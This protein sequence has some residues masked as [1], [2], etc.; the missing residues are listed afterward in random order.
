MPSAQTPHFE[1]P[2]YEG[3]EI[4]RLGL[5]L[6]VL[7]HLT[8]GPVWHVDRNAIDTYL[9]RSLENDC[10]FPHRAG[11]GSADAAAEIRL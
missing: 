6:L 1:L 7:F 9:A 11:S 5:C 2:T 8:T 10:S 3:E 4:T